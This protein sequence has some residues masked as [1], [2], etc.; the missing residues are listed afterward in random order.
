MTLLA[1]GGGS[2]AIFGRLVGA[3]DNCRVKRSTESFPRLRARTQRF[4]LGAPRTITVCADGRRILFLRSAAADDPRTGLWVLDL[5]DGDERLVVDPVADHDV[6]DSERARRERV[7]EGATGVVSYAADKSGA[8]AAI[9]LDGR[10][11]VVDVDTGGVR[12][13]GS[14]T[15]CFDPRPNPDGTHVAY[16]DGPDLRVVAVDASDDRV[17]ASDPSDAV[18][19]GRAEFVAAEEMHRFRGYWWAPDGQSLLAARVDESPVATWWIADPAHPAKAP[20]PVRYPAAGTPDADVTLWWIDLTGDRREIHWDRAA[21]PYLAAVSWA[22]TGPPLLTVVSDDQH[23]SAILRADIATGATAEICCDTDD[24]WIDLYEGSPT[25][26]GDDVVR[27][28][29]V[30][31][32]HRLIVGVDA[33]TPDDIC[34][35]SLVAATPDAVVFQASSGDPTSVAVYRWSRFGLDVLT[36]EAGVHRA[37][38]GAQTVVVASA[39]MDMAGTRTVVRAEGIEREIASYAAAPPLRPEV[40]MLRLGK[41]ELSAGLLLPRDHQPGRKLP[42]LLDPYGGPHAQRVLAANA[43]WLEPQWLADQGFAVLVVDGRGTPG[44]NPA[45]ERE[46]HHDFVGTVLDDQVDALHAAAE[47]EPDLDLARVGIRGWSF[48]GWLAGVAVLRRPDVFAA[49][50]AGAPV[51][52]WSLYDTYYTERYLGTPQNNPEVYQRHSLLEIAADLDRPLLI[53][54]GLADDNV[55]AAHSLQLSQRLTDAG[56]PHAVLPLTGV[57]HMTPQEVVAEN[58]LLLQVEFLKRHLG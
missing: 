45:W 29:N 1:S 37:V 38:A 20:T 28:A 32:Q 18:S 15:R 51:T 50:I 12:A 23:S 24:A 19:W 39:D 43:S 26:L 33:V 52:D 56:R 17:V 11:N 4:T 54:H 5:P 46:V 2:Q 34:V 48:G 42:V 22:A 44:R 16:V 47:I 21:F 13:V 7:R 27:I 6:P 35:R 57:T 9:A 41:R 14:M 3:R 8:V 53:I 49:A 55:V 36:P 25:W 31:G 30:D 40:R 58:L 10:L